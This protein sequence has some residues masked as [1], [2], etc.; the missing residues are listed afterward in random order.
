MLRVPPEDAFAPGPTPQL[1]IQLNS[2]FRAG[3]TCPERDSASNSPA[4]K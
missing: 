2:F 3:E 4:S 1:G